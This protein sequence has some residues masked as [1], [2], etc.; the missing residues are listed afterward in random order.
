MAV[1]IYLMMILPANWISIVKSIPNFIQ[2]REN[3]ELDITDGE[4]L[5][6]DFQFNRDN[7]PYDIFDIAFNV[8]FWS[9]LGNIIIFAGVNIP[10]KLFFFKKRR[11]KP[12]SP[13]ITHYCQKYLNL[14][15]Y[16]NSLIF[17]LSFMVINIILIIN[18]L[19]LRNIDAPLVFLQF[20]RRFLF[21]SIFSTLVVSF[22][23]F[24]W[25]NHRLQI[26][27]LEYIF[28]KETLYKR[29]IKIKTISIKNLF[30]FSYLLIAAIPLVMIL[31]SIFT[32]ITVVQDH[33]SLDASQK[34]LLLGPF[35]ELIQRNPEVTR[36]F[37]DEVGELIYIDSIN[38]IIMFFGIFTNLILSFTLS[39]FF[40]TWTRERMI[41]PMHDLLDNIQHM[42][43]GD[44][45]LMTIVKTNDEMGQLT[46]GFNIM[47]EKISHNI[48][49]ITKQS[50]A[51]SRFV[52]TQFLDYLEKREIL[53]VKLGDHTQQEM[54]IL[55]SDIR[56]FTSISEK[57]DLFENFSFLNEYL[58]FME[59]AISQNHGFIDKY[60]GD[61][62][63]A[64][65][66]GS[67]DGALQAA[68]EMQQNLNQF[69]AN[70]QSRKEDP[71]QIGIGIHTGKLMLGIIGGKNRMDSTVIADAV[72]IS[73]RLEGLNK[74]YGT[75][76]LI[77]EMTLFRLQDPDYLVYRFID[78][79]KMKGK[80]EP[81]SVFEVLNGEITE[82]RD[83]K[84]ETKEDF[85]LG[86]HYYQSKQFKRALYHFKKV[87]EKNKNDKA[88]KI[89]L[90]RC[91]NIIKYGL[92]DNWDGIESIGF[93]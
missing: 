55:F 54:S 49:Y 77:S 11:N 33:H 23:V 75:T 22:F 5:H 17:F 61:G 52:P 16:I 74:V 19:H 14:S 43:A 12:I 80:T 48:Q 31:F 41:I 68:I 18:L 50:E 20:F 76:I 64:L 70:R 82:I 60:I 34:E 2:E 78:A 88:V 62:I 85:E 46:E 92:P 59:P 32:N 35:Y 71:I 1:F 66:P 93:K 38:S 42:A 83:K 79:V 3:F 56:S 15:A 39:L 29:M 7:L 30:L 90:R 89:H 91:L 67:T 10:F 53:D 47:S 21:T 72:N 51:Y 84:L 27:Y 45:N 58:G 73:S 63:M 13:R 69:N 87:Y 25:Q 40:I 81:L 6:L 8:L 44:Q 37:F 26:K 86:F 36:T 9:F 65:F 57:M 28:P 24:F 4:E